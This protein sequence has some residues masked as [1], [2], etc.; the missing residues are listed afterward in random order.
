MSQDDSY[1]YLWLIICFTFMPAIISEEKASYISN[2]MNSEKLISGWNSLF[3]PP[4]G[5]YPAFQQIVTEMQFDSRMYHNIIRR[6]LKVD[7]NTKYFY[8]SLSGLSSFMS[9]WWTWSS[10]MI[11][12]VKRKRNHG[13][14][15]YYLYEVLMGLFSL[16]TCLSYNL[17]EPCPVFMYPGTMQQPKRARGLSDQS[18]I[19]YLRA[20]W[21]AKSIE[22]HQAKEKIGHDIHHTRPHQWGHASTLGLS[23]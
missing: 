7:S 13:Y 22:P 1:L 11:L 5:K 4:S 3:C 15:Q 16:D 21:G 20:S 19:S 23:Q 6:S 14:I 17:T 8:D 2:Q 9:R 10:V 12:R 18:I